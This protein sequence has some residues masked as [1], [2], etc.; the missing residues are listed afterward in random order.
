MWTCEF[1]SLFSLLDRVAFG[2][3]EANLRCLRLTNV[4]SERRMLERGISVL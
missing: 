4:V 1:G 2:E 3:V